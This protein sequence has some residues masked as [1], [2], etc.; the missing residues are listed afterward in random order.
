MSFDIYIGNATIRNCPDENLL[1][2]VVEKVTHPDSPVMPPDPADK[3]WGDISGKTNGRHPGY[4]Q[5]DYW[6]KE[7]GVHGVW[8]DKEI[9]L[10]RDHPGIQ[11]LKQCHL[12]SHI[13]AQKIHPDDFRLS[14]YIFWMKW[15]LANCQFP[16]VYNH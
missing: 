2:L 11:P 5:M 8:F 16:A 4:L 10:M 9:G 13:A 1:D 15:A 6:A 14:W 7:M 12:D 3:G